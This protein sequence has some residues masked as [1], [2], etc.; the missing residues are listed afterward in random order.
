MICFGAANVLSGMSY[1]S[2][3]SDERPLS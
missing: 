1:R 3:S 2:R